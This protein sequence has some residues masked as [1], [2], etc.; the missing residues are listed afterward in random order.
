MEVE[1]AV[2][3]LSASTAKSLE[4][5]MKEQVPGFEMIVGET[6]FIKRFDDLN[7]FNTKIRKTI[8]QCVQ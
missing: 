1:I 6:H 8:F 4:I 3:T 2:Q 7:E 5:L